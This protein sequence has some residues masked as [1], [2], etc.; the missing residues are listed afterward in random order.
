MSSEQ[1]IQSIGILAA[2]ASTASFAP[3]AWKII[4]TR[5]VD[6]LSAKMYALTV[7]G[8]LLWLS[9]GIGKGDWTLTG[10]RE[11][12]VKHSTTS[13]EKHGYGFAL[14]ITNDE[15]GTAVTIEVADGGNTDN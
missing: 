12:F 5:D 14:V 1:L 11:R 8:F 9:Y 2:V 7:V 4:S 6:G 13:V 10:Q 3:Q 15:I